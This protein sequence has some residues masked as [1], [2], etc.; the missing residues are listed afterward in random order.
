MK[1]LIKTLRVVYG[2]IIFGVANLYANTIEPTIVFEEEQPVAVHDLLSLCSTNTWLDFPLESS[3]NRFQNDRW[4]WTLSLTLRS[5]TALKLHQL[6]LQWD[7]GAID[8]MCASLYQ[9]K[10][11]DQIL[12][13]IQENLVSEGTWDSV[14]QQLVFNK[15]DEK[16]IATKKYYLVLS[17]PKSVEHQVKHGTF[18]VPDKEALTLSKIE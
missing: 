14:K 12:I 18:A 1:I 13:P 3:S 7:G 6:V 4:A 9:K 10:D 8:T 17:F 15:L 16:I 11:R 2:F 5:K